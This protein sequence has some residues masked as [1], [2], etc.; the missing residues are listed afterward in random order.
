MDIHN[1]YTSECIGQNT[2]RSGIK[3]VRRSATTYKYGATAIVI[4]R[5]SDCLC[6]VQM[7]NGCIL[8]APSVKCLLRHRFKRV[9][10][11]LLQAYE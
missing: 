1:D 9:P 6:D 11:S 8:M 3:N 7:T 5:Q 2:F 4:V 10:A